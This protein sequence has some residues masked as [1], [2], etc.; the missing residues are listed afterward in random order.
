MKN[1]YKRLDIFKCVHDAHKG[2][3]SR[4]SV[5]HILNRK[6]C[7]PEGC[8]Y[9]KW[10]C[11]LMK[12]GK[13]CYRGYNYMGK[14]CTGCR[15]F[16]EDKVHNHPEI[17][18]SEKEYQDFLLELRHFEDW[19]DDHINREHEIYGTVDGVK[20]L[21]RKRVYGKGES[22]SFAGFLLIFK[23]IFI[24]KDHLE[25]HVYAQVS[26]K[27]Y[28]SLKIGRGDRLSARATLKMDRGRLVFQKLR[29]IDIEMRGE[30]P[31]WDESRALVARETATQQ[32]TQPDGCVQCPFGALV[33]VEQVN[34]GQSKR[35]RQLYCLQGVIDY[36]VC[37]EYYQY[38][39][40][41]EVVDRKPVN[42]ASCMS[43]KVN[44]T[45]KM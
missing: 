37:P 2:F 25:D 44:V 38:A 22:F 45:L 39:S 5:H 19:L 9:F 26:P 3:E 4:M 42:A 41:D 32:Q 1:A 10:E 23:D 8:F 21:F 29:R 20:P 34:N 12:Q 28:A 16:H 24:G 36:R 17:Q 40:A 43:R 14:N 15:Y 6:G 30:P 11:K 35:Y 31:M 18:I 33:D 7:F 27:T 13:K